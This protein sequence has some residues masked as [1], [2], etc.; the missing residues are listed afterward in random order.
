MSP[1]ALT[2]LF[3]SG[4]SL[5]CYVLWE[6][7]Q[8]FGNL[9]WP[10]DESQMWGD[11]CMGGGKGSEGG[12]NCSIVRFRYSQVKCNSLLTHLQLKPLVCPPSCGNVIFAKGVHLQR[13]KWQFR[14][15]QVFKARVQTRKRGKI[16]QHFSRANR[17]G[18]HKE[19]CRT[20]PNNMLV[21]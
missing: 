6:K 21:L 4:T 16:Y 13:V 17:G 11:C 7:W 12:I 10:Q 15:R 19:V 14:K 2:Q 3:I 5:L 18:K 8:E 9:R 20:R 1:R